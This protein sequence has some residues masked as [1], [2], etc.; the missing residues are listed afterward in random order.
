MKKILTEASGSMTS[1]YLISS[2]REAGHAAVASDIDANCFG[3]FLADDFILMPRKSD[4]LLWEQIEGLLRDH[5][6]DVVIPSLDDTLLGWAERKAYFAKRG[7]HVLLSDEQVVKTF[8][9]K[10]LTYLAFKAAGIPTPEASLEQLYPLVKPRLGRGA[11]GVRVETQA[12]D[13]DGMISQELAEGVEYTIDVFCGR[14]HKPHYIV[15]RRRLGVKEGKSTGGVVDLH[16][17]IIAWVE[18]ICASFP[19]QGPVN[20]QCFL[21]SDESVRF[22]EINTRIAGGMAL[23]FAATENWIGLAVDHFV[24]GQ[25]LPE[26]QPVQDGMEMKRYYAEVFIPRN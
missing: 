11:V 1:G 26:P 3:R 4:P 19:F 18:Q 7:V 21:A 20:M 14:D 13:M 5:A 6:V 10:W 23:G 12:V 15:P 2:I 16:P 24:E 8:Q 9:D 17:G 22:I 25:P